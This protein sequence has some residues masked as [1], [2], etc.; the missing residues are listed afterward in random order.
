MPIF[1]INYLTRWKLNYVT[2]QCNETTPCTISPECNVWKAPRVKGVYLEWSDVSQLHSTAVIFLAYA[3]YTGLEH[4]SGLQNQN[5]KKIRHFGAVY[6]LHFFG[7]PNYAAGAN[8]STLMF[9]YHCYVCC[10]YFLVWKQSTQ[11][12]FIWSRT[13]NLYLYCWG[14]RKE[15]VLPGS[16]LWKL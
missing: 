2:T 4:F 15:V 9:S 3:Y 16:V 11:H 5:L 6:V 1:H 13:L 10:V 12:I 14:R 8:I 7:E